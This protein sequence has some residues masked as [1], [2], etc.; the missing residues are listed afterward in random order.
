MSEPFDKAR[1]SD[2]QCV[3]GHLG[4]AVAVIAGGEQRRLGKQ[5]ARAGALQDQLAAMGR[6][7]H[8]MNAAL[9]DDMQPTDAIVT[10]EDERSRAEPDLIKS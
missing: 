5:R 3:A 8:E 4:A 9:L 10:P 6:R 1:G 2:R 7:P